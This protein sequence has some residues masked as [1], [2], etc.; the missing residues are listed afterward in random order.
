M[1]KFIRI[2]SDLVYPRI[3]PG[4]DALSD[5]DVHICNGCM[6]SIVRIKPPYCMRCGE[7]FEGAIETDMTCGDCSTT[8]HHFL[9]ARAPIQAF[10]LGRDLIHSLKYE[11]KIYFARDLALLMT[12]LLEIPEVAKMARS[13]PVI[14]PVPLSRRRMRKRGYNQA[15]EIA[16]HFSRRCG[17]PMIRALKRIKDTQSQVRLSKSQRQANLKGAFQPRRSAKSLEGRTIFLVDDVFTTGSTANECARVLISQAKA[18]K[19][20]VL[21]AARG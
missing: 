4:C 14:V 9:F 12:A 8:Q 3:C 20:V 11:G 19:V 7:H 13:H 5:T 16:H 17:I 6:N 15:D 2:L 10:D 21:T 18:E 1:L